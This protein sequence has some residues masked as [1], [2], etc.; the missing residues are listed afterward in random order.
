[1]FS[2]LALATSYDYTDG[3]TNTLINLT[4]NELTTIQISESVKIKIM[5]YVNTTL[6]INEI[7]K[8]NYSNPPTTIWNNSIKESIV[9]EGFLIDIE[10][11]SNIGLSISLDFTTL[12]TTNI[13]LDTVSGYSF[14]MNNWF[15]IPSHTTEFYFE[16][17]WKNFVV[18][19]YDPIV[20][21]EEY[22]CDLSGLNLSCPK[23]NYS[24]VDYSF[25]DDFTFPEFNYDV[26][27]WSEV[28]F[29]LPEPVCPQA[30]YSLSCPTDLSCENIVCPTISC[31]AITEGEKQSI[32][33]RVANRLSGVISRYTIPNDEVAGEEI[34]TVGLSESEETQ[35][36]EDKE[37]F[38]DYLWFA[39]IISGL[40]I[41]ILLIIKKTRKPKQDEKIEYLEV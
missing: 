6:M 14:M 16:S 33:E 41:L 4:E 29:S 24:M 19:G 2:T 11:S 18:A 10:E 7:G 13:L 27:N 20:V 5:P 32:A 21:V 22:E 40:I 38:Y 15:K 30:N 31:P 12:D 28:N 37:R 26:I 35:Y 25:L 23:F 1:M 17:S 36:Q 9:L 39:I 34:M 3:T 8:K